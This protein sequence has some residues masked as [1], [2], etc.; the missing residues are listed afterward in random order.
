[1]A[2]RN[3]ATSCWTRGCT[4]GCTPTGC[5]PHACQR[6]CMGTCNA[7]CRNDCSSCEGT[8]QG[9]CTNT[10]QGTCANTCTGNCTNTCTG[11]CT[12][13][14]TGSCTGTCTNTCTTLCNTGCTNSTATSL[15]AKLS[16]TEFI[17]AAN[18]TDVQ[19]L[20]L[21]EAARRPNVSLTSLTFTAGNKATAATMTT[22]LNNLKAVGQTS[23]YVATAGSVISKALGQ[24]VISKA[25]AAYNT[26]VKIS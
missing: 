19:S 20:L 25:L 13:T 5:A 18:M 17:E 7:A 26:E 15:V 24:D 4:G 10:C 8:C 6:S 16:L 11:D 1:M 14:C 22:L 2:C 23:N 12:N 21:Q 3:C 9:T